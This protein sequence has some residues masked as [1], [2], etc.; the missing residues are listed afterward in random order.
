MEDKTL[1]QSIKEIFV[2]SCNQNKKE[3]TKVL[4]LIDILES[5]LELS[6]ITDFEV[7]TDD[8]GKRYLK[9]SYNDERYEINNEHWISLI[10][11]SLSND[12]YKD[13][14]IVVDTVCL[15]SQDYPIQY[16]QV[17]RIDGIVEKYNFN[18]NKKQTEE[19]KLTLKKLKH[20]NRV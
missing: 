4:K 17:C 5:N 14:A 13:L 15:L 2:Q 8:N 10:K 12:N 16:V 6:K 1:L 11:G 18:F 20:I 9:Y 3:I 7:L 19:K